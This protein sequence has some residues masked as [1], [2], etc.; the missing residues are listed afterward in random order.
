[1]N[2]SKK[3]RRESIKLDLGDDQGNDRIQEAKSRILYL[4]SLTV[5][6]TVPKKPNSLN[7]ATGTVESVRRPW[8]SPM[9]N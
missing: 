4:S 8:I 7:E 5:E 6:M 3:A 2:V 1:M 9:C